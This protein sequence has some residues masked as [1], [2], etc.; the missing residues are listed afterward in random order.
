MEEPLTDEMLNRLLEAPT[1]ESFLDGHS[2]EPRQLAPYLQELLAAKGLR[3]I[4]V[5]H[6]AGLNETHGYQIFT[7]S[8]SASRDKLLRLALAMGLSLTE[9]DRLLQAGGCNNLYAKNRRDAIIIFGLV[10]GYGVMRTDEELY[11]FGE[12]TLG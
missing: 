11:R 6:R 8:R 7:G 10:H 3:R 9:T 12:E 5:I 4:E 1:P 2:L